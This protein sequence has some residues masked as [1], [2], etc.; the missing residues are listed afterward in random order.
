[1]GVNRPVETKLELTVSHT[2]YISHLVCLDVL[3]MNS[4]HGESG[5]LCLA[6]L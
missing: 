5:I 2:S 3:G 6:A 1:V 4:P